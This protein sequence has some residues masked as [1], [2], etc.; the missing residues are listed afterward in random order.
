[1]IHKMD[2]VEFYF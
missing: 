1:M 2:T